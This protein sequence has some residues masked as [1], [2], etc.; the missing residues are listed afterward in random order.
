MVS[1]CVG[2]ER[3]VE[4]ACSP[5]KTSFEGGGAG[6][7][8]IQACVTRPRRANLEGEKKIKNT[9]DKKRKEQALKGSM[10]PQ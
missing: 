3:W 4:A 10:F 9:R 5:Y 1:R 2:K 6:Y 8:P 7:R